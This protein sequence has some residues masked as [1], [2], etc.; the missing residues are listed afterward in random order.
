MKSSFWGL[1]GSSFLE[2]Q[3]FWYGFLG[4]AVTI[5]LSVV[6]GTTPIPLFAVLA[7]ISILILIIATLFRALYTIHKEYQRVEKSSISKIVRVR[8]DPSTGLIVYLLLEFSELFTNDLMISFLYTDENGN[9]AIIGI[10]FIEKIQSN[11]F[12]R[13]V[14]DQPISAYQDILDKL[15]DE[16]KTVLEKII[17][18][19]GTPRNTP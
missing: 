1:I 6:A 3:T 9:E 2:I 8:K 11:G 10:G 19:P 4:F 18:I 16:N 5:V 12:M 13:A 15:A 17:V 14:I 7:I